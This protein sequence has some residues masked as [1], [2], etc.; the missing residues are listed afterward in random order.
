MD[1]AALN[2]HAFHQGD[3]LLLRPPRSRAPQGRPRLP[4]A[5]GLPVEERRPRGRAVAFRRLQPEPGREVAVRER[6]LE[7]PAE[8]EMGGESWFFLLRS[9]F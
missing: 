4:L 6:E 2:L 8:A 1:S 5:P 3:E 9:R 7:P